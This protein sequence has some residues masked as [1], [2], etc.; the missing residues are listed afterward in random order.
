LSDERLK[1]NNDRVAAREWMMPRIRT[2]RAR[3]SATELGEVFQKNALPFAPI[4]KPQVLLDDPHLNETSGL[5]QIQMNDESVSR[6]RL[7]PLAFD[8]QRLALR[9]QP[10][11]VGEHT[12]MLLEE[13]DYSQADIESLV[14]RKVAGMLD[15][16]SEP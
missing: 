8:G 15:F 13:L 12:R 3:F 11:K 5:A 10:P 14:N 2:S 6:I 16:C 9:I 1:T 7:T 4:T